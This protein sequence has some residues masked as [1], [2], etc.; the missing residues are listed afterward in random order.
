M[1][2]TGHLRLHFFPRTRATRVRWMLEEL[3]LDYDLRVVDL[4]SGEQRQRAYRAIHPFG[5]VPALE[6]DGV[7]MTESLAICLYLADR[8]PEQGLAPFPGD[9]PRRAA[10]MS[11][12][13]FSTGTLEPALI[14]EVRQR[15]A[16]KS[17]C[18]SSDP[19][20]ALTPWEDIAAHLE[21]TLCGRS[22]LTGDGFT[23]ADIM[24][25][26][27]MLWA[28]ATGLT[29]KYPRIDAWLDAL[30]RRPACV[31]ATAETGAER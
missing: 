27:L 19:G 24:N 22:H 4:R 17:G 7:A 1:S 14:E 3:G 13:A 18:A 16:A 29:S 10:Y 30:T 20:P 21:R 8:Y 15:E 31:R 26:S 2:T 11:W 25:G 23:A 6:I 5:K 28:R 12:M 9:H